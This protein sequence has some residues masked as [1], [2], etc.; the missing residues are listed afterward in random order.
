[1][2]RP[3]LFFFLFCFA[4]GAFS[5]ACAVSTG[6]AHL[7][8]NNARVILQASG[9]FF[10]DRSDGG[11]F[12]PK[13]DNV[14][15]MFSGGLWLGGFDPGGNLKIAAQTYGASGGYPEW[16]PGPL[17]AQNGTINAPVCSNFNRLWP[18]KRSAISAHIADFE[19][20]G[21]IDGPVPQGVLEWP[22]RDN[23]ES[24]SS[25]GFSLP[26]GHELAPF[27]DRNGNGKYEPMLGDYPKVTGD[28]AIW[29]IFNDEGGGA[30]HGETNGT[31]IRAEI[32][33][34][35]YAFEGSNDE[36]LA[37]TTF[38]DFKLFNR[39][40]EYLD[41]AFVGLWL[42]PDMGCY[43][44]DYIGCISSE[45]LAFVYNADATDG[46]PDCA[47]SGLPTYCN[48]PPITGVKVLR[49]PNNNN[50]ED[51]GFSS[52]S[53]SN[54]L[55]PPTGNGMLP[56]LFGT[57]PD[58]TPITYGG[59]G[60]NPTSTDIHPFALDGNPSKTDE[61]SLCTVDMPPLDFRML[62][63]SGP[64]H[65]EPGEST[66]ICYA[67]M[68]KFGV[69]Y[70]CPD[71]TPLIEMGNAIEEFCASLSP[72]NEPI[73]AANTTQFYPNPLVSEGKLSTNGEQMESVR[74]FNSNG[75][76]VRHYN[77][78]KTN[79]LAIER[80]GLPAGLYYYAALLGNGQLATGKIAIQ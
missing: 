68:T 63:S 25:N 31:P 56:Q 51:T 22:G 5:Q 15:T 14:A 75:Q 48:E 7:D 2:K 71:V 17:D 26:I 57:W 29:W 52:F 16:W 23:P 70:P 42:D 12:V 1:M 61:W 38:Y 28:Q 76:L 10:W 19:S 58:G 49:G 6:I 35:A 60:Y 79:E 43:L 11:Y 13:T 77:G 44:D 32:H 34:L 24:L 59:S 67:V 33:A 66:S 50:G 21:D 78:L 46:Q 72:A 8:V 69:N 47:C 4:K 80:G 9:D 54:A 73:A 40:L 74:L 3:L 20:D 37:N 45:K 55:A 53:Y 36:N 18:I 41:S 64:F 30:I 39:A 65:L 27:F 62:I